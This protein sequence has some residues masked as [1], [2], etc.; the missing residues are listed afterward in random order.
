MVVGETLRN[1]YRVLSLLG[2]GGFSETYLAEDLDLP[3]NPKCVVK[4]LKPKS[5]DP[6]ILSL[7]RRMFNT[8]AKVLQ[9][10]GDNHPQIPTLYAFYEHKGEFFLV[11]EF[12]DGHDLMDELIPGHGLA[13]EAVVQMVSGILEVLTFVHSQNIIHRDIKPRNIM[14]RHSDGKIVLIDFGAV[15]EVGSLTLDAQGNTA[16][17]VAIGTPTYM[18]S[19]QAN[20]KPRLSSDVYAVG[21]I[22]IQALTGVVPSQLPTDRDT[23]EVLWR[24]RA[25]V[26]V[27]FA[28]VVD[29]MVR[30]HFSLRFP[31]ASEALEALQRREELS[32]LPPELARALTPG[33][34]KLRGGPDL[35]TNHDVQQARR[36]ALTAG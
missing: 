22:A 7:A 5:A 35:T 18:P 11:Q 20:G 36:L 13:E 25:Q 26:S 31:S 6:E 33:P 29:T 4:Y 16:F 3:L 30:D 17:T 32:S 19:E 2:Q 14:R 34:T 12:V 24:D 10:L 28:D 1:R 9:R 21:R 8:E 15:K 23:G 27:A